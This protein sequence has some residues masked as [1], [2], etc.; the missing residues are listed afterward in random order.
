LASSIQAPA[1]TTATFRTA[2]RRT[3]VPRSLKPLGSRL[4]QTGVVIV[5]VTIIS[6]FLIHLVPGD[7]AQTILGQR[8]SEE[9]LA[10][11]RESLGLDRPL[12]EQFGSFV[13]QLLQGNLGTSATQAGR[14]VSDI[15]MP[16]LGVTVSVVI[17]ATIIGTVLGAL[18]G[19]VT[20]FSNI[21]VTKTALD[22]LATVFL[23]TPS[24][25]LGLIMLLVVSVQWKLAPAGGWAGAWPSNLMYV[26]LPSLALAAYLGALVHRAVYTSAADSLR[27]NYVEAVTARGF[28][29]ARIAFRHVLPNSLLPTISI[30]GLNVGSL[31]S[32]AAVIEAV[33]DLP[34]IGTRL[35]DAVAQ[36][37]YPTIQAAALLTALIVVFANLL[38]DLVYYV[39]DPRTR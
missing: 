31:I 11:V 29:Q 37:D 16:A 21:R 9:K 18:S 19:V 22:T 7:P 8:A 23:A 24:F 28:G 26:W 13:L 38:A 12:W 30:V 15:L 25:L 2:S 14:S 4:L 17:L 27:Q 1:P 6:F 3:K 39:I 10:A 35:V 36:R 32:G 34:G 20:A 33:F 5:L